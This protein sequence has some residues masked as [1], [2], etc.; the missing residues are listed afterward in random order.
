MPKGQSVRCEFTTSAVVQ[1]H[2]RSTLSI[3]RRTPDPLLVGI[4]VRVNFALIRCMGAGFTSCGFC[5]HS[6]T[7]FGGQ[8][9]YTWLSTWLSRTV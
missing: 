2:V 5:F 9:Y 8:H 6:H 7:H 1:K 3:G 4:Y